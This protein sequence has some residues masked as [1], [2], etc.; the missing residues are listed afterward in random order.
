MEEE[1]LREL[2]WSGAPRRLDLLE[3]DDEQLE[4]FQGRSFSELE[5]PFRDRLRAYDMQVRRGGAGQ[6]KAGA[7]QCHAGRLL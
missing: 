4:R 5:E 2:R 1:E 3:D 7:L 6:G